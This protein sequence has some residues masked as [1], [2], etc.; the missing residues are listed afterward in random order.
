MVTGMSRF[1]RVMTIKLCKGYIQNACV[2]VLCLVIRSLLKFVLCDPIDNKTTLVQAMWLGAEQATSL[3][4]NK[5]YSSSLTSLTKMRPRRN[6]R[7]FADD[8]S[9]CIFLNENCILIKV[10]LEFISNVLLALSCHWFSRTI[11]GDPLHSRAL[12]HSRAPLFTQPCPRRT[13]S[14][15]VCIYVA[16]LCASCPA[17]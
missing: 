17:V 7:H 13:M 12:A 10:S 15:A 11:T 2:L 6:G 4:M 14:T 9:K 3:Y 16:G 8:I 1:L 5:S